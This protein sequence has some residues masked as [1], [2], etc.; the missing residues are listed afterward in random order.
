[1]KNYNGTM[2]QSV[3]LACGWFG[4]GIPAATDRPKSKKRVVTALLQTL[5]VKFLSFLSS[6]RA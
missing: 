5:G 4:D 3:S 6:K 2:G 1:M